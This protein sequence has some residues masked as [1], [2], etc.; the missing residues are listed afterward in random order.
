MLKLENVWTCAI[1]RDAKGTNSPF[2]KVPQWVYENEDTMK[3][4]AKLADSTLIKM[5]ANEKKI[6]SEIDK[7]M[8]VTIPR[9]IER[10]RQKDKR[11]LANTKHAKNPKIYNQGEE[12]SRGKNSQ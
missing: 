11:F 5:E 3:E 2:K 4:I 1:N 6:L 7:L 10:H 8:L 9:C 12:A